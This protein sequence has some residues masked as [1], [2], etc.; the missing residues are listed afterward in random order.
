VIASILTT[1]LLWAGC[2]AAPA[3]QV[4]PAE[5]KTPE[6]LEAWP[7]LDKEAARV[8]K[9]DIVRL[10]KAR[11]P[12]M[13]QQAAAGLIEAGAAI[14]PDLLPKLA[15]ERDEDAR[16]RILTVLNGVTDARHTRLLAPYFE[17]RSPDV[18][19]W[20]M[21]R[22][23][24]FPDP[25]LRPL[26]EKTLARV[27][28]LRTK[29]K[30]PSPD[31]VYAAGLIA[32]SSGSTAGLAHVY[33]R[34][35]KDWKDLWREMRAALEGARGTEST[36]MVIGIMNEADRRGKITCLRL[37]AGCGDASAR[38]IARPFLDNSDNGLRVAAV[39]ALR[40]IVDGEAP[41]ERLSVFEAIER[42]N[43]WKA[44]L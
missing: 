14:V 37:L 31:E 27:D 18:R 8:A 41:I 12:E 16:E 9:T 32:T 30:P 39:N 40:G 20:A 2:P 29:K 44:R 5:E 1:A 3:Q 11:T 7:T 4:P 22:A 10:R 34:A 43:K 25:D 38:G 6:R 15:K 28:A 26:A 19:V 36:A 23:A 17:D 35:R 42:A 24:V 21:R 33:E 13:G